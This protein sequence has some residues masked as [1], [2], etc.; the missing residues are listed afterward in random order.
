MEG[1]GQVQGTATWGSGELVRGGRAGRRAHAR[2]RGRRE[3][4]AATHPHTWVTQAAARWHMA[5]PPAPPATGIP[6]VDAD[7][8]E[9]KALVGL[10]RDSER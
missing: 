8:D 2:G 5:S 9:E 7:M 1:R 10:D 4:V 6:W 3:R